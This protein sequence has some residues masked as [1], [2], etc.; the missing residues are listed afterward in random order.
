[1]TDDNVIIGDKVKEDV[2]DDKPTEQDGAVQDQLVVLKWIVSGIVGVGVGKIV[3]SIIDRSV[4]PEER[5]RT[6]RITVPAA[7]F[8]AGGM[9]KD[10]S[11]RYTD[12]KVDDIAR[13]FK[14]L[15]AA[16]NGTDK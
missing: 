6:E 5:T 11:R 2:S 4:D 3:H 14:K 16:I 13:K 1:M 12:A 7:A 15:Q 9:A 8:V 10:A